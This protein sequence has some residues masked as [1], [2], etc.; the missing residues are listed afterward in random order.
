[1]K[2][3]SIPL[4]VLIWTSTLRPRVPKN[5]VWDCS[6]VIMWHQRHVWVILM[7]ICMQFT[8]HW[9]NHLRHLSV[10]SLCRCRLVFYIVKGSIILFTSSLDQLRMWCPEDISFN[11]TS[12]VPLTTILNLHALLTLSA[13]FDNDEE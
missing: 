6:V 7:F 5:P 10:F 11:T 1:M 4:S 3:K 13:V 12:V 9:L 2:A 8:V